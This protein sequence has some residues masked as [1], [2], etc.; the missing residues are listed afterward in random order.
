MFEREVK[1]LDGRETAKI[2]GASASNPQEGASICCTT[3]EDVD[4]VR[5]GR[6]LTRRMH[7]GAMGMPKLGSGGSK[8]NRKGL[9]NGEGD[10]SAT[11]R[12]RC[13]EIIHKWAWRSHQITYGSEPRFDA[14]QD[15]SNEQAFFIGYATH[16]CGRFPLNKTIYLLKND[17]HS[18]FDMRVNNVLA[19]IPEFA[20]AFHCAPGTPMNP[21][22]RCSMY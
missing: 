11:Y 4:A 18:L 13:E 1:K 2:S 14:M 12:G 22:K 5:S 16:F 20:E 9:I 6:D 7:S 3:K 8:R 10:D 15:F 19:N 17:D 21:E